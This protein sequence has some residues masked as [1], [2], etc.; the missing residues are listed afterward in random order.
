MTEQ[1]Q[2]NQRKTSCAWS[3]SF[4]NGY[5]FR[6]CWVSASI[7]FCSG[8]YFSICW[9]PSGTVGCNRNLTVSSWSSFS[10]GLLVFRK[11]VPYCLSY[12]FWPYS[13]RESVDNISDVLPGG[14]RM[15]PA[16]SCARDANDCKRAQWARGT[17][18]G[19]ERC[20]CSAALGP[21]TDDACS[22][23]WS[24]LRFIMK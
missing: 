18:T 9:D 10:V 16:V 22:S 24:S 1:S 3:R 6:T 23:S 15:L 2:K 13:S 7:H 4:S 12:L 5:Q 21:L 17:V 19:E 14:I 11:S 8:Q 20:V